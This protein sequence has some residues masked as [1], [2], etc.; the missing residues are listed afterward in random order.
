MDTINLAQVLET[1]DDQ[2]MLATYFI[3]GCA[4]KLHED[5]EDFIL[6]DIIDTCE[7][8]DV[9]GTMTEE[10]AICLRYLVQQA[11]EDN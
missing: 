8:K 7:L 1:M 9:I 3:V 5:G 2:Q 4:V 11:M 6:K 10:Q